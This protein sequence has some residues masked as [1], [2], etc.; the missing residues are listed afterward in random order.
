MSCSA[1]SVWITVEILNSST[2]IGLALIRL[3]LIRRVSRVRA[4]LNPPTTPGDNSLANTTI[5]LNT[6]DLVR[7]YPSFATIKPGWSQQVSVVFTPDKT[8][9]LWDGE[10]EEGTAGFLK[11][12]EVDEKTRALD[13]TIVI[14]VDGMKNG[15]P[16][17]ILARRTADGGFAPAF[18][19][20]KPTLNDL[21]QG[22]VK[23]L[24]HELLHVVQEWDSPGSYASHYSDAVAKVVG[25]N[26]FLLFRPEDRARAA[27]QENEFEKA[28]YLRSDEFVSKNQA[29][30]NGGNFDGYLPIPMMTPLTQ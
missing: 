15:K 26:P 29:A 14:A 24:S 4:E 5:V 13:A 10:G 18:V 9:E 20:S 11:S 7:F 23:L 30:I 12:T 3:V 6:R 25:K 16:A 1:S 8:D 28:A 2:L 19:A 27:Y 22:G 17:S 21:R